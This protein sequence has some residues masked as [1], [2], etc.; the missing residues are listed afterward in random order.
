MAAEAVEKSGLV[1]KDFRFG[2][3]DLFIQAVVV[4]KNK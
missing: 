4:A 2:A 1:M 3:A